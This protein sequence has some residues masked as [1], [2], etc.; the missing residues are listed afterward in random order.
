M[1]KGAIAKQVVEDKLREVFDKDFIGVDPSTKKI[2]VQAEEDGE[3]IQVAINLT[4]PK[5]PFVVEGQVTED[6]FAKGNFSDPTEFKPAE[7]TENEIDNVR[8][9]IRELGL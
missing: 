7:M 3:M 9:L 6:G 8:R 2:Y 5:T 4:C 1:A